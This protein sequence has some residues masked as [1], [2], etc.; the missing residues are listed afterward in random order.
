MRHVD[1]DAEAYEV[2][3]QYMLRLEAADLEDPIMLR[4]LADSAGMSPEEFRS[5][6]AE[7]VG[8]EA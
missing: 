5:R 6:F 2:A 7:S 3:R 4:T 1:I 8:L